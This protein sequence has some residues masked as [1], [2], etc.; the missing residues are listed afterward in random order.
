[1]HIYC[2]DNDWFIG[3]SALDCYNQQVELVGEG[4]ATPE[5]E[6][7]AEPDDKQFFTIMNYYGDE[8]RVTHTVQ[9]WIEINGRGLLCSVNY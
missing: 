3:E 6:W 8:R 5:G 7:Y 9:E 1:M 2:D 4:D